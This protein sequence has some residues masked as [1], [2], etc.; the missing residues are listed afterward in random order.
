[1]TTVAVCLT[2]RKNKR[3][4]VLEINDVVTERWSGPV[5]SNQR[6][7]LLLFPLTP[8]A[9]IGVTVKPLYCARI[10][11]SSQLHAAAAAAVAAPGQTMNALS[12]Q[13]RIINTDRMGDGAAT[14]CL[15]PR[16][17]IG[18]DFFSAC[19]GGGERGKEGRGF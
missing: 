8:S 1:M 2:A 5:S 6:I 18:P 11:R 15:I 16:H 10:G 12:A 17:R 14:L 3:R 9:E 7:L 4:S 19:G 13:T